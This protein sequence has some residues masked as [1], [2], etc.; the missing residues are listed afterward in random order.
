MEY[1]MHSAH[2]ISLLTLDKQIDVLEGQ[3]LLRV[4]S[5]EKKVSPKRNSSSCKNFLQKLCHSLNSYKQNLTLSVA[6]FNQIRK[7]NA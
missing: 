7:S 3:T 6:F 4:V 2:K 5:Q 1:Y